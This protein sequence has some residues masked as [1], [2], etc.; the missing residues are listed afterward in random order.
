[1]IAETLR[2][3]GFVA[4]GL[5]LLAQ[6]WDGGDEMPEDQPPPPVEVVEP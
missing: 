2:F 1:M 5:F 6:L 3:I 4:M